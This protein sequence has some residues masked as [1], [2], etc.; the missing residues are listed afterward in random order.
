MTVSSTSLGLRS[1]RDKGAGVDQRSKDLGTVITVRV[2]RGSRPARKPDGKRASAIAPAS[3]SMC[4]ASASNAS[5]FAI[6]PPMTSAIMDT[7]TRPSVSV[8]RRRVPTPAGALL[9]AP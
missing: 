3:E 1:D 9:F 5:K 2:G 8:R 6:T 7:E 4:P